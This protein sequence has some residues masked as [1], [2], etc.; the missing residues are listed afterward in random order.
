VVSGGGDRNSGSLTHAARAQRAGSR[1]DGGAAEALGRAAGADWALVWDV[2]GHALASPSPAPPV[3]AIGRARAAL[4]G[5]AAPTPIGPSH[6]AAEALAESIP[7]HCR[8]LLYVPAGDGAG[9]L[10]GFADGRSAA[11]GIDL[12]ALGRLAV[13][14]AR[15]RPDD[16]FLLGVARLATAGRMAAGF[17][18]D[19]GTP[20]NIISGYAEFLLMSAAPETPAH[21]GLSAILDQTRRIAQMVRDMVDTMRPSERP[22]VR[23]EPLEQFVGEILQ[24]SAYMLRKAEV[25]GQAEKNGWHGVVAG[26]L[27][28]LRHAFFNILAGAARLVGPGGRLTLR[29]AP[30]EGVELEGVSGAG[31]PVDLGVLAGAGQAGVAPAD[32]QAYLEMM[33]VRRVLAQHGGGLDAAEGDGQAGSSRLRVR[34]A[35]G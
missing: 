25:K 32:V 20:L 26:D 10:L 12:E 7:R 31:E 19:L 11:P 33:L 4:D 17:A 2:S 13:M 9:M 24:F 14:A 15:P 34:L 5:V 35:E 30:G 16:D 18:H 6:A 3:E 27:H 23:H 8:D 28:Q 1:P 29:P 22:T 21:K